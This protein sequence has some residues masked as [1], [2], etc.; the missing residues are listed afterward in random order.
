MKTR[1]R[2]LLSS[3]AVLA[4]VNFG[5]A[6]HAEVKPETLAT[7]KSKTEFKFCQATWNA[8]KKIWT[9]EG[10]IQVVQDGH[11]IELSKGSQPYTM[12]D[13]DAAPRKA[14]P[15]CGTRFAGWDDKG[16]RYV[17]WIE[18]PD[19]KELA[20]FS[21][22]Y[23]MVPSNAKAPAPNAPTDA[24]VSMMDQDVNCNGTVGLTKAAE[25]Y[26]PEDVIL[27]FR[28]AEGLKQLAKK[29]RKIYASWEIRNTTNMPLGYSPRFKPGKGYCAIVLRGG[30]EGHSASEIAKQALVWNYQYI[31][32]K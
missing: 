15:T 30:L 17:Y 12:K 19:V 13:T 14:C 5:T 10:G 24:T 22:F 23:G 4:I 18:G 16:T 7:L 28:E 27:K 11:T 6:A 8:P 9:C 20:N 32:F 26:A 3:I 29:K 25:F 2:S 1:S 21:S 31:Q